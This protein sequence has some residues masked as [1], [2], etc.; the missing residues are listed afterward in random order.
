MSSAL[1]RGILVTVESQYIPERSSVSSRQFAFA[2]T[3]RIANQGSEPAQLSPALE[4]PRAT[5]TKVQIR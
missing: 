1:T 5:E 3:V 2:Y 4:T